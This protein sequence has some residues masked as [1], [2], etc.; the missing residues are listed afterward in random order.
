MQ[1]FY[2]LAWLSWAV[3]LGAG[4]ATFATWRLTRWDGLEF[5]GVCIIIAGTIGVVVGMAS[6]G[7]YVWLARRAQ[8]WSGPVRVKAVVVGVLLLLNF[9]IA[10][11]VVHAA[12]A[13]AASYYVTVD[14]ATA[15]PLD[16]AAVFVGTFAVD[17]GRIPPAGKARHCCE[18]LPEGALQFRAHQGTKVYEAMVD[19]YVTPGIGGDASITVHSDGTVTVAQRGR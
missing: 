9:P 12:S 19:G 5:V 17:L 3:P 18:S 14:N 1:N 16:D 4:L 2:R 10:G 13:M 6:L 8:H 7:A 15:Q 11:L